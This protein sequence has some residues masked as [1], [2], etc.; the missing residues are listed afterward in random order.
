M[1]RVGRAAAVAREEQRAATAQCVGITRRDRGDG[2]AVL[3]GD[4]LRQR[5]EIPQTLPQ[6]VRARRHSRTA[7]T[8][9]S[10]PAA[11]SRSSTVPITT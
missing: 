9:A 3:G 1:L 6:P 4:A 2:L 10:S 7:R 5:R 8:K 11:P